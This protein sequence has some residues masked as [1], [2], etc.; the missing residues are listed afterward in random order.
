MNFRTFAGLLL[1]TTCC[2]GGDPSQTADDSTRRRL[3]AAVADST[4][5]IERDPRN[6]AAY[7]RRGQDYYRLG[8]VKEAVAHFDKGIQLEPGPGAFPSDRGISLYLAG[9]DG[10]GAKGI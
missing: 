1:L 10:R 3:D 6:V 7:Q 8:K 2:A 9:G 5:A 4:R